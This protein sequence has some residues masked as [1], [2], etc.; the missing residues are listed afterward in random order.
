MPHPVARLRRRRL[1][2][3]ATQTLRGAILSGRLQGGARLRQTALADQLGISRTPIREALG[4]LRDEGLVELLPVGGLR[5]KVM[6][7]DEAVEHYDLREV[8]DG[9]A[10]RLA[11]GRAGPT[12]LAR[13]ERA[14][15]RMAE[16]VQRQDPNRWFKAHVDF[17]EEILRAAGNRPLGR[18]ASVVRLSIRHFHPLLLRTERRLERA[19]E[20]HRQIHAAIAAHDGE[21]AE[22]LA[23]THIANAKEIVLK[24][25]AQ[26]GRDAAVQD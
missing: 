7:L 14:L 13:L 15:Q 5:V 10:A 25:M 4:Q 3:D 16:C 21:A 22:R 17:H 1:V 18:L 23:R 20:E 9:L 6:N 12:S 11:A 8:L 26:G 2:D 24:V 19:H